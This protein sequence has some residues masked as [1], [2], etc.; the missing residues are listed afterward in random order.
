M[1]TS[2]NK[3]VAECS[4]VEYKEKDNESLYETISA[5]S[6]TNGGCIIVGIQDKTK[7]VVGLNSTDIQSVIANKCVDLLG[8]QPDIQLHQIKDK[9]VLKIIVEKSS[10]PIQ[11]KGKYYKRIGDTTRLA[12]REEARK[13][14]LKNTNWDSLNNN[15]TLEDIDIN[16]VNFFIKLATDETKNR[17]AQEVKTYSVEELFKHLDLIIDGK[18]TNAAVMLFGKNPQ[19]LFKKANVRI[20]LFK[21]NDEDLIIGDK[22]ISGNLFNQFKE[23]ETAIKSFIKVKYNI[24]DFVREEIWEYPLVAIREALLNA[25]IHKD[26][27]DNNSEIQIKIFDDHIWFYN[28]GDLFGGLTIEDLKDLHHPSR[29]R[30]P[31]IMD[32]IYKAGYVE[33]FGTGIK[34]MTSACVKQGLPA[35]EIK[36]KNSGFVLQINKKYNNIN[37][38]QENAI[39]YITI[40]GDITNSKYQEINTCSRDVSKRD[41]KKLVELKILKTQGDKKTLKYILNN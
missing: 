28:N 36:L 31:L 18:L 8:I 39:R 32:V 9:Y 29:P 10:N 14:L 13:M 17:L 35:P 41:L 34:R 19:K 5:F 24:K 3:L 12:S 11:M 4:T 33:Q 27:F 1:E 26:Y 37:I 6:N 30:N 15:C 38:R 25:L 23:A 21:G 22:I 7:E 2:L 16:S 20:G 40:N